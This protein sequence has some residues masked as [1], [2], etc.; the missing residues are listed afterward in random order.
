MGGLGQKPEDMNYLVISLI[1]EA[2]LKRLWEHL[3]LSI[4]DKRQFYD[5]NFVEF[6][7]T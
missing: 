6:W 4:N 5:S 1:F 3:F 2:T 7:G